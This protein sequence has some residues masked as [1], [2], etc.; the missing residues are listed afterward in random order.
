MNWQ[1]FFNMGGYAVFV[2]PCYLLSL[3]ALLYHG[4][5]PLLR[6]RQFIKK[7]TLQLQREARLAAEDNA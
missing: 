4:I 6:R 2:W 5:M 3:G 1:E 7:L